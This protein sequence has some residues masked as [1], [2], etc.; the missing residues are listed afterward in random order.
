MKSVEDDVHN[1]SN[2]E[3]DRIFGVSFLAVNVEEHNKII[4]KNERETKYL[5]MWRLALKKLKIKDLCI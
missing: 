5:I 1:K 4:S 2:N 3:S